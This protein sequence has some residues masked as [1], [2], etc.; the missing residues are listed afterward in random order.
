MGA[1]QLFRRNRIM[2][3]TQPLR[4]KQEARDLAFYYLNKGKIR[5]Y[6]LIV[7][8]LCTALRISD[9]LRLRWDDVYDFEKGCVKHSIGIVEKKTRKPKTIALNQA[10]VSA[11]ALFATSSARKG[12]F[13]IEN[14]NTLN[15]ISR[16]QAYRIIR[17]AAEALCLQ[18]RVSCHSLR[19]TF[20]YHA[21]KNGTSPVVIMEIYNHSSLETTRRYLGVSQDDKNKVYLGLDLLA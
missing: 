14:P 16:I 1:I 9:L 11:L 2:A 3:A 17:A 20:G 8:G 21:W 19:K 5:N 6:V 7:L 12:R 15:A 4:N 10:A 13:L 18:V